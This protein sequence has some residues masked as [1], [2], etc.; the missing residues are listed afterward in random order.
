VIPLLTVEQ[1]RAAEQ[2]AIAQGRSED[3]LT[4]AAG[5]GIAAAVIRAFDDQPGRAVILVGPGK[6]GGDGLVIAEHLLDAGWQCAIWSFQRDGIA[7]APVSEQ[8]IDRAAWL[9]SNDD[10]SRSLDQCDIVIDAIYGAGGRAELPDD[11]VAVFD[12]VREARRRS[13]LSIWAVDVP[14]GMAVDT[15]DIAD[16]ALAADVT[17]M[18][19]LPKTGPYRLPAA[20]FTGRVISIDIGL[21]APVELDAEAP[22][23]LTPEHVRRL[24]PERRTGSHKRSVG[25]VLVVGGAPN[26]YGAP[27]MSAEAALRSGAGLVSVAAPS[28]IIPPIA[29][30]VPEL[31]FC[32]LPMAEHGTAG[33]RMAKIVR[34]RLDETDAL[35]IGP[36]LGTDAPVPDF[37][38]RLFGVGAAARRGIG[39]GSA[40]ADEQDEPFTGRA[41][42]DAD[43]LNWLATQEDWVDK[44]TGADLVLTPHPGELARMTG[45]ERRD[46]EQDPWAAAREA[47]A[48][49][50][51]VVVLKFAHTVVATPD[52]RMMVAPQAP[53][54]LATAGTGDVLSGIIGSF[55][56]QGMSATDAACS[57]ILV[58]LVATDRAEQRSGPIGMLATDIIRELPM[59]IGQFSRKRL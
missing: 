25:T 53:S 43:A 33:D 39:F 35:V 4:L 12:Q 41:V 49:F 6:N 18:I 21:E 37:L 36:G 31:T 59:A 14:S 44:L 38:S 8:A 1:V 2:A 26:Y 55:M 45:K 40:A 20:A 32:P 15:G 52:G 58:G 10:L 34:E 3:A 19:G 9:R 57:G 46:I 51:H 29:T 7:G 11:V 27:R 50:K 42:L 22:A 13:G 24:L 48:A 16:R 47:A 30:A 56:A 28:S 23:L 17:A 54:S 5:A